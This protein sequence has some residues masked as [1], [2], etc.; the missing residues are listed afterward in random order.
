M[1]DKITKN[2]SDEK[3]SSLDHCLADAQKNDDLFSVLQDVI[4][5]QK[6]NKKAKTYDLKPIVCVRF[7]T[8]EDKPE[9]K[10][11]K[12]LIDSGAS[13]SLVAQKYATRHSLERSK[14]RHTTWTTP[15]G[16]MKTTARC[17]CKFSLPEFHRDRVIEWKLHV[18][19]DL[20]AYD[21]ILGR[22]LLVGLGIVID[23]GNN[24]LEWDSIVIPMKDSDADVKDSYA[25]QEP[26]TIISATD[27]L[28]S[29]LDAKYEKAELEQVS[30]EAEHLNDAE[31]KQLHALLREFPQ[32]FDGS[33]GKWRIGAYDIELRPDAEPYHA[34]A[35]LFRRRTRKL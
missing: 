34:R 12:C 9:F 27:R 10:T 1:H 16:D 18:T 5:S 31:Q 33:L 28:K 29:I 30:Q 4:H 11:L 19:P 14:G 25:M 24:T 17:R 23:F 15:A 26:D 21:M 32:L 6:P 22:D 8:R 7:R 3:F 13:A 2:I 20:G 35:F